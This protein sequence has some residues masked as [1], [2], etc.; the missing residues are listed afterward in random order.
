MIDFWRFNAYFAQELYHEQP[1]SSPGM[2]NQMEYRAAR[3]LRLRRS[4]RSTSPR[5]AA[6]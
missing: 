2:W 6:T 3:G 4:R 5:S 1:I